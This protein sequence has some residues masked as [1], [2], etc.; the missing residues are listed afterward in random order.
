MFDK[1]NSLPKQQQQLRKSRSLTTEKTN[2]MTTVDMTLKRRSTGCIRQPSFY[3][4]TS[5][6]T[7]AANLV[8]VYIRLYAL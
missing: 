7:A 3:S 4:S 6:N 2:L 5:N 1:R 8:K